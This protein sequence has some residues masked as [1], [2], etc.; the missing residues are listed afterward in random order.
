MLALFARL[1]DSPADLSAWNHWRMPV[2]VSEVKDDLL[3][4]PLMVTIEY[5][6]PR[7]QESGFLEAMHKYGRIRRRD[8]AY[9]WGIFRDTAVADHYLEVFL[10]NSWAEH[11]RQ[12]ERQTQADRQLEERLI[13]HV[14]TEPKVRHLIY[15][16]WKGD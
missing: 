16:R 12:H 5:V 9:R 15:S 13:S 14:A 3:E 8:G 6:V 4:G 11:M 2:V 10:V 7:E 1:P